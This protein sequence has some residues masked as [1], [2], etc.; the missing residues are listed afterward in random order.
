VIGEVNV[1]QRA[2]MSWVVAVES[3]K[4]KCSSPRFKRRW[5]TGKLWPQRG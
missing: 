1:V 3:W 5:S 2:G 4:M